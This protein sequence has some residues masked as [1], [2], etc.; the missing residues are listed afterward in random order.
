[1]TKLSFSFWIFPPE[2]IVKRTLLHCY[3]W[4][5]WHLV[6]RAMLINNVNSS[7]T[8]F[9]IWSKR[10]NALFSIEVGE[11]KSLKSAFQLLVCTSVYLSIGLYICL[12][13]FWFVCLFIYLLVCTSVYLSFGLY[14]CLSI[15][16]SVHLFIYLFFGLCLFINLFLC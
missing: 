7:L 4:T 15:Y 12:S 6:G 11:K 10:K 16:W 2:N 8:A 9:R 1:M 14:V 13:I 5:L 3:K